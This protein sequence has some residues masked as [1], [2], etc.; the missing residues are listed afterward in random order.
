MIQMGSRK[1]SN[2]KRW[3][4]ECSIVLGEPARSRYYLKIVKHI[5]YELDA[6]EK[7]V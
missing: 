3:E 5:E 6:L 1:W 2:W 7:R 4:N